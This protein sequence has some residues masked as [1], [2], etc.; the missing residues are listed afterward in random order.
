M[1]EEQPINDAM[2]SP[3]AEL[4]AT[5]EDTNTALHSE[6]AE[7]AVDFDPAEMKQ[8][9]TVNVHPLTGMYQNWFLDYASYVILERAVP[10]LYDGL[11][12]VQRRILHTMKRMDDGRY[13]KVANIAGETMKF[14]PHGDASIVDA[15]TQMGRQNLLIDCQGSWGN[16]LTGDEAAA[17]RYIEGRLTKF[18]LDVLFNPKT[19]EWKLSYDGRNKEPVALPVKFPLLLAQGAEG[20]A[21]GL[22][23]KILPHN[24]GE[25]C[26]A[27]ISYLK[28]EDF[29]LYPDFQ[30]GGLIDVS[31]YNDGL[32]GGAVKVRALVEKRDSKTIAITE[33]PYGKTVDS[34]C[35]S[36]KKAADKGRIKIRQIQ[37]FTAENVEILIHLAPGVSSDKTLDALYAFTDC[38]VSISPNCCIIDKDTPRFVTVK[39]VLKSNVENTKALLKR[40]LEIRRA[41]LLESMMFASLERIFI[42]ERIYKDKAY[43]NAANIDAALAHIDSR[44]E[45]F[46]VD[47]VREVVREDLLRL[48]EIK[49]A[50]ILKF[51]KAKADELIAR[52]KTELAQ[53]EHD[54]A[55]LT[56]VTIDWFTTIYDRYAAE[57][58]RRTEIRSFDTIE[59]AKVVEANEKLYVNRAD[60]FM[61]TSLKKDEFVEN[62]SNIDDVIIFYRDG[63]YKVTRVAEKVYIGETERSKAEKKKAEIVHIAVFKKNDQRTVYNVAYRDGKDGAYYVKRFNVTSIT[64]DREYDVTQ[65]APGSKIHYFTANPNGEAE[66][67]KVTLKPNPKL[68]RI[69]FEKSFSELAVKGRGSRGN[70]L[71]RLDVHKITLKSHGASTLGGRKV[72]FDYDVQRL[73][74]DERGDYL[75]EFHSDD[76][77]LVVLD[78]GD[79]Y[80]TNFDPNNHYESTGLMRVEKFDETKVWTAVLY[81]ADNDNNLYIKRFNFER[82][83]QTRHQN[84]M[85]DNPNCKFVALT[86]QAYPRFQVSFAAPDDFREPLVVDAEEFIAVKGFKAKGKR[87][88]TFNVAKVEELEPTRFPEPPAETNDSSEEDDELQQDAPT[89][90]QTETDIMDDLTGQLKLGF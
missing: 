82:A 38:E 9:E 58:P 90:A 26:Q 40:E 54:L 39:E 79:F 5:A 74:F 7:A 87:M 25:L 77:V 81:D 50:R 1:Q 44:L 2:Q 80:T 28:G 78:N 65:G 57:H 45:P 41:E 64:H 37:D 31:R 43:E 13:N 46:K 36:I 85:G 23:A 22:S 66:V 76:M 51:N 47:F 67:I 55:H 16:I 48:L 30:T 24:F 18:A 63:T 60:G 17:P 3:N 88:T 12:P 84:F 68:R 71:T 59:A 32:R 29:T 52:I 61:G 10:H 4:N 35:E 56:E 14:H 86:D 6:V 89:P 8:D 73:N 70:L 11:K 53:I 15:L 19:T 34:L 49:M 42:D 62:C 72:W 21:V 69:F 75:G 20:I 83:S 27:A 33:L